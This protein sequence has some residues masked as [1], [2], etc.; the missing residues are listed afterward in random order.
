[1]F[2]QTAEYAL[3]IVVYLASLGP[4]T[5]ATIAQIAAATRI[6]AG[7]LAKVLLSLSKAGIV[8]SQR[9]LHGGSVLARSADD[10]TVYDVIQAVDPIARITTCPLGLENHG[11]NL[12]PLHRRLDDAIA[13][14]EKAFRASTIGELV[15]DPSPSK[16]LGEVPTIPATGMVPRELLLSVKIPKR[17]KRD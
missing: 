17:Q 7:Y 12:C 8:R 4:D 14:V 16:P 9:G 15:A 10:V 11:V 3:R 1:V 6:P 13:S 5:P 2:S